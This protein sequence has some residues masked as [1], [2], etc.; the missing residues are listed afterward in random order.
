[1]FRKSIT[2]VVLATAVLLAA[3]P[4]HAASLTPPEP[5]WVALVWARLVSALTLFK[6][7]CGLS[8][9]PNGLRACASSEVGAMTD[10]DGQTAGD[11]GERG[12]STDPNGHS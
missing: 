6:A 1:M 5:G 11:E 8:T 12:A 2:T 3:A 9:D 10:P 4:V 7:E